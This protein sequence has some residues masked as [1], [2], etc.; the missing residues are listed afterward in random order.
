M[1]EVAASVAG[2]TSP[3]LVHPAAQL[4]ADAPPGAAPQV[5]KHMLPLP[6]LHASRLTAPTPQTLC[7]L[8]EVWRDSWFVLDHVSLRSASSMES[9]LSTAG[10][11]PPAAA[12]AAAGRLSSS[13]AAGEE[14][15]QHEQQQ[16]GRDGQEEPQLVLLLADIIN[17]RRCYDPSLP[18]GGAFWVCTSARPQGVYL[19]SCRAGPACR[20][21]GM[22]NGLCWCGMCQLACSS[23]S[24]A[25]A[26]LA[27]W[28]NGN[29]AWI[30]MHVHG[31]T[32]IMRRFYFEHAED[33]TV[34]D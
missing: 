28:L 14:H 20:Q 34:I 8:S 7:K 27:V 26:Q 31:L 13:G 33:C 17:I 23:A 16:G 9:T 1:A 10:G 32:T 18:E 30:N 19:V 3:D 4:P 2:T 11:A 22:P 12:S 6:F 5:V 25:S 24:A 29:I 21:A 15:E